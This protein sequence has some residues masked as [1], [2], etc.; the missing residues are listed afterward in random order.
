MSDLRDADANAP[1]A[2]C[3]AAWG[4]GFAWLWG[5]RWAVVV[6]MVLL[7]AAGFNGLWRITPDSA[8]YANLGRSLVAGKGMV[9]GLGE[10]NPSPAGLAAV[11]G[12][13]GGP[14][15]AA[16]GSCWRARRRRWD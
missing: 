8:L 7:Y 11:L 15:P 2:R 9:N 6:A 5:R 10:A 16:Q 12:W 13:L 1:L 3:L 14:G 4:G